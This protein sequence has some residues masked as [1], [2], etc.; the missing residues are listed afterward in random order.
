MTRSIYSDN[1]NGSHYASLVK[2]FPKYQYLTTW[3]GNPHVK[4][5]VSIRKEAFNHL[6]YYDSNTSQPYCQFVIAPK[7]RKF[8]KKFGEKM[9][10]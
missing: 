1:E 4:I 8:E 10:A 7:L 6:D 9:R 2:Q 5:F 3:S